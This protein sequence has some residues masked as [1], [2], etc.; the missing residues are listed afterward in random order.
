[1]T[2]AA[3]SQIRDADLSAADR[4]IVLGALGRE[5]TLHAATLLG[6]TALIA[7][8]RQL[9]E[10]TARRRVDDAFVTLSRAVA[11]NMD[12]NDDSERGWAVRF[13]PL[14]L[15]ASD[16]ASPP[17]HQQAVGPVRAAPSTAAPW[18]PGPR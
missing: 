11:K 9:G 18:S 13:R 3:L 7:A 5:P 4:G 15:L 8:N 6:R 17:R 1:L 16:P 2:T 12:R 14:G 10:R